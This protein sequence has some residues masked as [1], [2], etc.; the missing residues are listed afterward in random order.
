LSELLIKIWKIKTLEQLLFIR[1]KSSILYSDLH[2]SRKHTQT[3]EP[4]ACVLHHT[5]KLA[6]EAWTSFCLMSRRRHRIYIILVCVCAEYLLTFLLRFT[7]I[8]RR[9]HKFFLQ[10]KC[11]YSWKSQNW[12]YKLNCIMKRI[13]RV[14]PNNPKKHIFH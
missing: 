10:R 8:L 4:N 5:S 6:P 12:C 14:T 9:N 1:V 13:K 11:I 2:E 3:L 7:H